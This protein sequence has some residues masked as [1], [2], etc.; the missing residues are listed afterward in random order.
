ME[1]YLIRDL[2]VELPATGTPLSY[3]NTIV[4]RS[5]ELPFDITHKAGNNFQDSCCE[6]LR[7]RVQNAGQKCLRPTT[8]SL[9]SPPSNE[10]KR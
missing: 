1:F 7:R 2:M 6:E 4:T 3:D 9:S 5:V 10:P 8:T